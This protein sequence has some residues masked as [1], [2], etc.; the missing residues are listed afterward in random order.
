MTSC[1]TR[2]SRISGIIV[3]AWCGL[4]LLMA[5]RL[6]AEERH[7]ILVRADLAV[8]RLESAAGGK[9]E[10]A[11]SPLTGLAT[12]VSAGPRQSIPLSGRPEQ[13]AEARSLA[14]LAD[15]GPAFGITDSSQLRMIRA[16]NPDEAGTEHVRLQQIHD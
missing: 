16:S 13:S 11:R 8:Q 15:Y 2:R 9:L 4:T 7:A 3:Q 14:F 12:F 5:H 10:V 1:R 6:L